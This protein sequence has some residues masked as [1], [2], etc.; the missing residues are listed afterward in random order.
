MLCCAR[1]ACCT[2][3][4]EW[5]SSGPFSRP[6]TSRSMTLWLKPRIRPTPQQLSTETQ[7][8]RSRESRERNG[9]LTRLQASLLFHCISAISQ[10][11]KSRLA[12]RFLSAARKR[13]KTTSDAKHQRSRSHVL[14]PFDSQRRAVEP[15]SVRSACKQKN[16]GKCFKLAKKG[17]MRRATRRESRIGTNA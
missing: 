5:L 15:P 7:R 12:D 8:K 1:D 14:F 16:G 3:G 10:T 4:M 6:S 17:K 9:R 2:S 13:Q 11:Q